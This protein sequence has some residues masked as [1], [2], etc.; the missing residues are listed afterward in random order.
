M[1]GWVGRRG[2]GLES[3]GRGSGLLSKVGRYVGKEVGVGSGVV[4]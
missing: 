2:G 3:F 4:D 1:S